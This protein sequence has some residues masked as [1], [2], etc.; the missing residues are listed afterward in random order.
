MIYCFGGWWFGFP[1]RFCGLSKELKPQFSFGG[2]LS[3]LSNNVLSLP[4]F[5]FG[6]AVPAPTPAP[7]L[8][9]MVRKEEPEGGTEEKDPV[10]SLNDKLGSKE[11]PSALND[12]KETN[13]AFSFPSG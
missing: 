8:F 11:V 6:T 4:S 10:V 2:F 1:Q 3:G 12:K 7:V 13:K 9:T 5:S